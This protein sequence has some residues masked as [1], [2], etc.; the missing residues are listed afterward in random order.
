MASIEETQALCE[1]ILARLEAQVPAAP[2][3]VIPSP[4]T[5]AKTIAWTYTFDEEGTPE[6]GVTVHLWADGGSG[7][8]AYSKVKLTATSNSEGVAYFEIPRNA[9]L[10]FSLQREN[11]PVV[12]FSGVDSETFELPLVIG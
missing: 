10:R 12:R 7:H 11:G 5:D 3:V 4:S 9:D 1:E 6:T 8:G 2:V